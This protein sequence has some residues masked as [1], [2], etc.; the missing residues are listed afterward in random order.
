[1]VMTDTPPSP[2]WIIRSDPVFWLLRFPAEK[3]W[4]VWGVDTTGEV[5][6]SLDQ[7]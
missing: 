4:C 1:M 7:I 5:L 3:Q 2:F 6:A